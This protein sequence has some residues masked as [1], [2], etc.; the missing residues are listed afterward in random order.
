MPLC[1][2]GY[3]MLNEINFHIKNG[4]SLSE[5]LYILKIKK[6][7]DLSFYINKYPESIAINLT[8]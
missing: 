2:G 4:K 1:N 3:V 7:N 6:N 8:P 5:A